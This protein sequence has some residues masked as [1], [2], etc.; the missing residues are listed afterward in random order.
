MMKMTKTDPWSDIAADT[1]QGSLHARRVD[2]THPHDFFWGRD[3]QGNR[4]L[5]YKAENLPANHKL[6]NLRGITIEINPDTLV[7][8][9]TQHTDLEI[10]ST[11]CWSLIERTRAA[12]PGTEVLDRIVEQLERWQRFLGKPIDR[13]LSDEQIRGLF[14]EFK[15]IEKELMSR[16]G[17]SAIS[18]WRGPLGDP[19]DFAIGTALFEIKSHTAGAAAILLISSAD[20]LWHTAGDLFL[21][22]YTIGESSADTAGAKSLKGLV[23]QIRT[24]LGAGDMADMFEDRLM[25]AGYMDHPEY[26]RRIFTVA[27]PDFFLVRDDFPR[28]TKDALMPG[29]CRVKYGIELAACLLFKASPDWVTLGTA[30]GY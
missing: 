2:A 11:L 10:F 28:I 13:L 3:S 30:N 1:P 22:A 5:V 6:P 8:R 25:E 12:R 4:L 16:Y 15:F 21:V 29:V 18:F 20:Q 27:E 9:L 23:S 7:L 24:L 19:Q 17:A 14:C 26:D